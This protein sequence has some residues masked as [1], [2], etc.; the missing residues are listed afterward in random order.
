MTRVLI[1]HAGPTQWDAEGR[2]T[3]NHTLPL[4]DEARRTIEQLVST[5]PAEISAVYCAACNEAAEQA[6][7]IIAARYN[8][9]PRDAEAL[10][11][12]NLGLWQGLLREQLR[13]RFP[14]SFPHWEQSPAGIN[15][16]D[17][18]SFAAARQRLGQALR[19][20]IK[21]NRGKTIALAMRPMA[22]QMA[23]GVLR[24]EPDEQIAGHLH[25]VAL[26]ETIEMD[27]QIEREL[28]V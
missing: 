17:G 3:G 23:A 24:G 13:F 10:D 25:K 2:L 18:E 8:L 11:A 9:R 7:A 15:P 4:T 20:I 1:V 6:A 14:T 22:Q 26:L 28:L 5:L 27:E 12:M 16:P 19:R 21:R